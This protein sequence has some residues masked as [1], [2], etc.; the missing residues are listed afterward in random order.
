MILKKCVMNNT[1]I[2]TIKTP[3]EIEDEVFKK[4]LKTFFIVLGTFYIPYFSILLISC[5]IIEF[6]KWLT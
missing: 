1:K 4:D 2:P 6:F 3:I 5:S